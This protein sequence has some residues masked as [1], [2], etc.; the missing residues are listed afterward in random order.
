MYVHTSGL[1][2]LQM[3]SKR[4]PAF[5]LNHTFVFIYSMINS[6]RV[7]TGVLFDKTNEREQ[8]NKSW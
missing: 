5:I 3:E 6:M 1:L 4:F 7:L 2:A 8:K